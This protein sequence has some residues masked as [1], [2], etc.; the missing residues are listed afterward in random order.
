MASELVC[1]L[2][3]L[4]DPGCCR[5]PDGLASLAKVA[6]VEFCD[7]IPNLQACRIESSVFESLAFHNGMWE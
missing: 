2:D 1:S 7:G 6:M 4:Q 3:D 5:R